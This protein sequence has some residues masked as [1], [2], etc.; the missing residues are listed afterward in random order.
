MVKWG[1]GIFFFFCFFYGV[2][3]NKKYYRIVI[4]F[5]VWVFV[6]RFYLL[7]K[8]LWNVEY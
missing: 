5:K 6:R 1:V 4:Y 2:V 8:V 3:K 7:K